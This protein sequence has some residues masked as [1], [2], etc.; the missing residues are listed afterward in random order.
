MTNA[1]N[2]LQLLHEIISKLKRIRK[3]YLILN[4]LLTNILE[5]H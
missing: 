5:G 4:P 2:M 1:F 3:E